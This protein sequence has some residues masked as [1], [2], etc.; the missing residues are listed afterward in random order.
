MNSMNSLRK[1]TV[2]TVALGALLLGTTTRAEEIVCHSDSS[3]KDGPFYQGESASHVYDDLFK[4]SNVRI[5]DLKEHVPQGLATWSNWEANDDLLLIS[6][7]DSNHPTSEPALIIGIQASSGVKVGAAKI[8]PSHAGGIAVF[9][10]QGWVFVGEQSKSADPTRTGKTQGIV[11]KYA[12]KDLKTAIRNNSKLDSVGD[13]VFVDAASFLT[14]HG[15]SDTL[16]AGK[17]EDSK[18]GNMHA[19]KVSA[20][21]K[22]SRLPGAWEAPRK[23]QGLVVTEDLFIFSTSLGRENRS[24][25]YVVRRGTGEHDLDNARL[26]CFRAPSMSEGMAIYGKNVYLVYESAANEYNKP[27][28]PKPR[29]FIPFLHYAPLSSLEDRPPRAFP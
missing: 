23:T 29:N 26:D 9:E 8:E 5:T 28:K 3:G 10:K 13:P 22:L 18:R 12:L 7:Y 25:I 1:S 20:E 24:N 16:W 21:G 14:S 2:I 11:R 27:D 17:F 15:P 6:A 19:Y 4:K